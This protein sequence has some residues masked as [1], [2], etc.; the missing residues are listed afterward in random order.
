EL[1][2]TVVPTVFTVILAIFSVQI[3]Y[4]VQVQPNNGLV[5]EAIGHQWFDDFRYPGVHGVITDEMHLPVTVPVTLHVTSQDV[6]HSFWLPSM[7]IKADMVP[8][9]INTLRFTPV[10]PGRYPII[11]TEFCGTLHGTM[12]KQVVVIESQAAFDKW[13]GGWKKKNANA[14]DAL[15]SAGTAAVSLAGG[16]AAAGQK[17][18]STKCSACH[19]V[20][21]FSQ[22]IVGPGLKGVLHDP[23]HPKLVDGDPATPPNVAKILQKG[24]DGDLGHMPSATQNGLTDKDI[25]DLVAY[26][27]TLK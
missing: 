17:M 10:R 5:V 15:P 12:N 16:D 13:L 23:A 4:G 11:C 8:G 7:R 22:K 6:I 20:G 24:Y 3:W 25:A 2:W 21:P 26:L 1:W 18:F 9:L 27:S 19:A 14:S